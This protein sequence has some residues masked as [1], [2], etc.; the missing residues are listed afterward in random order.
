MANKHP[1]GPEDR[2]AGLGADTPRPPDNLERDPGIGTAKGTQAR[3]G[4]NPERIGG[5]HTFEGD[6]MNDT[7]PQGGI[8]PN[9]K[10]RTNR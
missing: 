7:T 6:V 8:N 4:G 2:Q 5:E 1:K 3:T 9:Q 10:G